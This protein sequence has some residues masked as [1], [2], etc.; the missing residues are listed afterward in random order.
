M[1]HQRF[2]FAVLFLLLGC[3]LASA[4]SPSVLYTWAGTG[5]IAQWVA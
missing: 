4:Q 5:D 1:T 3:T 2:F